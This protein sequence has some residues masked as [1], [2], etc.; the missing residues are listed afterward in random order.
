LL[1]ADSIF[2]LDDD[3]VFVRPGR[4]EVAGLGLSADRSLPA[5]QL[6]DRLSS[7]PAQPSQR[8]SQGRFSWMATVVPKVEPGGISDEYVLSI[9]VFH[10]RPTDLFL[11]PYAAGGNENILERMVNVAFSGDGTSGGEVLLSVPT[12]AYPGGTLS[13]QEFA[14][15]RLKV[16]TGDW[17]LLAGRRLIPGTTPTAIDRFQWYRVVH[18]D[19]DVILNTAA[20][21]FER[22]VTLMGRDWDT[23]LSLTYALLMEGVVGVYEKTIRL[24]YGSSF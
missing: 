17:L 7:N 12:S 11:T 18:V 24:E 1:L 16:R 5:V 22:Y 6:F 14:E 20:N 23:S 2:V 15:Q 19:P 8:S 21:R 10:D 3:L 13:A 4:D 9:V